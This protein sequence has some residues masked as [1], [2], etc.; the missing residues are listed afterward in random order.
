[1]SWT[2]SLPPLEYNQ[3]DQHWTNLVDDGIIT[4]MKEYSRDSGDS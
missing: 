3:S 1:M 4:G 2:A